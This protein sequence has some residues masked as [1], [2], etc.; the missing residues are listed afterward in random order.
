VDKLEATKTWCEGKRKNV[1]FA[2]RDRSELVRYRDR[3]NEDESP[4]GSWIKVQ[5]KQRDARRI[6]VEKALRE[7]QPD[8]EDEE[9]ED[10]DEDAEMSFDEEELESDDE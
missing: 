9:D 5:R 10:D 4:V 6:E 1:G 8:E 3:I 7:E 2:P